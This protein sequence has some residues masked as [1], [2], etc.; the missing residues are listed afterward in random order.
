[1]YPFAAFKISH[2]AVKYCFDDLDNFEKAPFPIDRVWHLVK[3]HFKIKTQADILDS[4]YK[5]FEKA[6]V[7]S[8]CKKLGELARDGDE[9]AL[10]IFS[11]AG[12][13]LARNI[14]AVVPK[15][16][17]ELINKEGGIHVLCVGSVWLSWDLLRSGF[18]NWIENNTKIEEMSLMRLKTEMGVGA[19]LLA[20]DRLNLPLDRDYSKNYTIFYSYK[21]GVSTI[22][23]GSA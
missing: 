5:D 7:A 21:R 10:C 8:L 4:F 15:V 20:S 12:T 18:V 13:H 23:N 6:H 19:A 1:M 17:P 14:N 2:R 9:L 3:E 11:E 22:N 16:A